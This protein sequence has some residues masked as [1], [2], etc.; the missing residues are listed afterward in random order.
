MNT[1]NRPTKEPDDQ[2][3]AALFEAQSTEP[4]ESL[5]KVVLAAAKDSV[6]EPSKQVSAPT[7]QPLGQSKHRW[8]ALAATIVV[9][10]SV[11][12][13]LL[14]SP[15][16]SLDAPLISSSEKSLETAE[17]IADTSSFEQSA[18]NGGA[19]GDRLL[20]KSESVSITNESLA[21]SARNS[22]IQQSVEL[23]LSTDEEIS[24]AP[25]DALSSATSPDA[26]SSA[27]AP[28]ALSSTTALTGVVSTLT[29]LKKSSS[30]LQPSVY[31]SQAETW[32]NEIL[33]LESIGDYKKASIE[34]DLFRIRFPD[35]E[36][37]FK[38]RER[39]D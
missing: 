3:I 26:L 38:L 16:S 22:V 15:E 25:Q 6:A 19:A 7:A 24:T 17:D 33:R 29:S 30:D 2:D 37:D 20:E 14:K 32:K 28:D 12:P 35:F 4:P 18:D 9:G 36:P 8:F 27:A 34:Y 31:R 13:L 11:A 10:V 21:T 23:D 39:D 1:P 5:D